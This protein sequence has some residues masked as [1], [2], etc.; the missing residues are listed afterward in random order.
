MPLAMFN[1]SNDDDLVRN[2]SV[3][4]SQVVY[5]FTR[6]SAT[7]TLAFIWLAAFGRALGLDLYVNIEF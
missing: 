1:S 2:M 5:V 4:G 3:P 6:S 7:S